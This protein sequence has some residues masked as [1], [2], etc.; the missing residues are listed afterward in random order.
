[1]NPSYDHTNE[2]AIIACGFTNSELRTHL[3]AALVNATDEHIKLRPVQSL[4]PEQIRALCFFFAT[5]QTAITAIFIRSLIGHDAFQSDSFNSASQLVEVLESAFPSI[6][7]TI[8][9][10]LLA[11]MTTDN[12]DE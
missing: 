5:E 7:Q 10:V 12:A 6:E 11:Q 1:M 4:A 8:K 2:S 9:V 3:Q